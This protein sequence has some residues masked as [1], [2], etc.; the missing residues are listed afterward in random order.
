MTTTSMIRCCCSPEQQQ[1]P[2]DQRMMMPHS[3]ETALTRKEHSSTAAT[4]ATHTTTATITTTQALWYFQSSPTR[5]MRVFVPIKSQFV[6]FLLLDAMKRKSVVLQYAVF[7]HRQVK[8]A[9]LFCCCFLVLLP[10][11]S[12]TP[13]CDGQSLSPSHPD[14]MLTHILYISVRNFLKMK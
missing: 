11:N 13:L 5:C 12:I 10:N 7:S 3:R 1:Q 14:E 2:T 8:L 6:P 9:L 4:T